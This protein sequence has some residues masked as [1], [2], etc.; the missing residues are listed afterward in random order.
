MGPACR[1][2]SVCSLQPWSDC[3]GRSRGGVSVQV[4][5]LFPR[6]LSI[7]TRVAVGQREFQN[8]RRLRKSGRLT[9][10]SCHGRRKISHAEIRINNSKKKYIFL[11]GERQR[12]GEGRRLGAQTEGRCC[13]EP[14]ARG[15]WSG[16]G[17]SGCG[18]LAGRSTPRCFSFPRGQAHRRACDLVCD[19]AL[20]IRFWAGTE[21]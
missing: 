19:F 3:A 1:A 4:Q 16:Q 2:A 7:R 9:W 15:P 8:D 20:E 12:E 17:G 21:A 13:M 6:D 18:A 5:L 11:E 10:C 14:E